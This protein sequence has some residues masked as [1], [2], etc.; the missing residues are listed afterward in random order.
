MVDKT[1]TDP[2]PVEASR[3]YTLTC[4]VDCHPEPRE[5]EPDELRPDRVCIDGHRAL[6]VVQNVVTNDVTMV[7]RGAADQDDEALGMFRLVA[8]AQLGEALAEDDRSPP[9][10]RAW[11]RRTMAE[12]DRRFTRPQGSEN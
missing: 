11:M 4:Q 2:D 12:F 9:A 10:V 6:V 7:T 5:V 1:R 8:W 3:T